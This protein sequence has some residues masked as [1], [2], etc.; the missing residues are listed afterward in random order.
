MRNLHAF[1]CPDDELGGVGEETARDVDRR[2]GLLPGNHVQNP[3]AKFRETIS[4][5]EDVVVRPRN[6]DSAIVLQFVS[7]Q[8]EP[9][10]VELLHLFGRLTLVPIPFVH[11]NNL[12]ALQAYAAIAEKVGRVRKYHVELEAEILQQLKRISMSKK[13]IVIL[14]FVVGLYCHF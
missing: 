14:R 7:T 13:E 8:A 6:P 10:H 3:V 11:T 9:F 5:R 2:I 1:P 4:H 12:A